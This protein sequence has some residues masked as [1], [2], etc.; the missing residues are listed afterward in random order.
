[1]NRTPFAIGNVLTNGTFAVVFLAIGCLHAPFWVF[2]AALVL[3]NCFLYH[4]NKSR[5]LRRDYSLFVRQAIG[6]LGMRNAPSAKRSALTRT[7]LYGFVRFL[8]ARFLAQDYRFVDDGIVIF[9]PPVK[10][11][12][13]QFT[14]WSSSNSSV[15]VEPDGHTTA[16]IGS[17]DL[18][19]LRALVG[20]AVPEKESLEQNVAKVVEDALQ[21]FAIGQTDQ[22]EALLQSERDTDVFRKPVGKSREHRIRG[23]I[24]L[25]AAVCALLLTVWHPIRSRTSNAGS[26]VAT[27][28]QIRTALV[29][30]A[31]DSR[32]RHPELAKLTACAKWPPLDALG[33]EAEQR[34]YKQAVMW[35]L[36]EGDE[37]RPL[38]C[39][40]ENLFSP[41]LLWLSIDSG[42][43]S[44]DELASLGLT[45]SGVRK[46]LTDNDGF[47]I[48]M[49]GLP[50]ASG[51]GSSAGN[52]ELID[53]ASVAQQLA[54]LR[55]F[56]CLDL[57]DTQ[58][59]AS[60]IAAKQI[61]P[62]WVVPKDH[63]PIEPAA[64]A[65]LFDFNLCDLRSTHAALWALQ[66]LGKLELVDREACVNAIL[67]YHEGEGRFPV[68]ASKRG[69]YF[70]G[71]DTDGYFALESLAILGAL[72]RVKDLDAWK[73]QPTMSMEKPPKGKSHGIVTWWTVQ[74]WAFQLRLEELR[75]ER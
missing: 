10:T 54:C 21:L 46:Y 65:G 30:W 35:W 29:S 18:R 68:T 26:D 69:V 73:F 38:Q 59:V 52:H 42:T 44:M 63:V 56:G 66:T 31:G 47:A 1:M 57:V 13:E 72:D 6:L 15:T 75:D 25:V 4:T 51:L 36:S 22:A 62:N 39:I 64:G 43:L 2:Y 11:G 45:A 3:L 23:G 67:R 8:G 48:R 53:I 16:S 55:I 37:G 20:S 49:M 14:G 58:R 50:P 33:N 71:N 32:P 70:T 5:P 41:R 34:A 12:F 60:E 28:N 9:L 7:Q 27:I 17:R 24:A 74:S 19:D 40:Y 61:T